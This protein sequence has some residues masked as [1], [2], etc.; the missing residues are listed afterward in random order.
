MLQPSGVEAGG[1]KFKVR[2]GSGVQ[3]Q[4]AVELVVQLVDAL[5]LATNPTLRHLTNYIRQTDPSVSPA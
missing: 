3:G 2:L 4:F 1:Q 5:M